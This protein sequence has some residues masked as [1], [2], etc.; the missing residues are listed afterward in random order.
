MLRSIALSLLLAASA[1]AAHAQAPGEVRVIELDSPAVAANLL[2]DPA[3]QSFAI[4]LPPAYA[5]EPSRR[6]PVLYLLHGIGGTYTDFT[7]HWDIRAAMARGV[8]P[9][10]QFIVVM[11]NGRNSLGGSFYLDSPVTGNWAS[12]IAKEIV[13]HVD[14]NFRTLAGNRHRGIAGH[15]MGG[16]GAL[17]FAMTRPELF[18]SVYALS[19]CCLA[20]VD[21]LGYGN[22]VLARAVAFRGLDDVKNALRNRDFY[23]AALA[24]M[25][26][27]LTPNPSQPLL[28]DLPFVVRNGELMPNDPVFRRWHD[29]LPLARIATS[30]DALRSL[31]RIGLEYGIDDQF[32]HIPSGTLLFSQELARQRIPHVLNVFDGDHREQTA[33]RLAEVV[34]PF[35]ARAF[36]P[37]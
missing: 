14:A 20:Q 30:R 6:F 22:H 5:S 36:R 3:R 34:L 8:A 27:A 35:F 29:R 2:G 7:E 26:M 24:A 37:E 21:D 15:S 18:G 32:A 25:A 11:P 1:L 31:R 16:F 10:E 28:A 33:D 17:N 4:Y 13:G 9:A 23:P 12:H 19:P